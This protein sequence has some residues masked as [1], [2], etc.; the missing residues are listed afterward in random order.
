MQLGYLA[1]HKLD[2]TPVKD[3]ILSFWNLKHVNLYTCRNVVKPYE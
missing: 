3:E 1:F 2:S